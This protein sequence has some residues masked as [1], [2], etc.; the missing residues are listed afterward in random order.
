MTIIMT[1][2]EAA[3]TP[4]LANV[5]QKPSLR[6]WQVPEREEIDQNADV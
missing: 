6:M 1:A 4:E 2:K 3:L 5:E